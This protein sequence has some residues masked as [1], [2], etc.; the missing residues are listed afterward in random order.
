[1][2]VATES[3]KQICMGRGIKPCR[4]NI[5]L[6]TIWNDPAEDIIAGP[7]HAVATAVAISTIATTN[8]R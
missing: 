4:I 2:E 8:A 1:M 3:M 5:V 7:T 6:T